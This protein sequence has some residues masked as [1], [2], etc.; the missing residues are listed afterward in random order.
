MDDYMCWGM[1]E[2]EV[3]GLAQQAQM[4]WVQGKSVPL[5]LEFAGR[6]RA[7]GDRQL[8]HFRSYLYLHRAG[9]S[10]QVW[11]IVEQELG[12]QPLFEDAAEMGRQAMAWTVQF[13]EQRFNREEKR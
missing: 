3:D 7:A 11:V 4:A 13:N 1:D 12:L 10:E 2:E 6:A 5:L 9:M 8:V